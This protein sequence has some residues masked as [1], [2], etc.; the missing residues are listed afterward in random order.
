M[1]SVEM[2]S[3]GVGN[4]VCGESWIHYP[5]IFG[6]LESNLSGC[7]CLFAPIFLEVMGPM[8]GTSSFF[9]CRLRREL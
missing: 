5:D 1:K 3:V 9:E 4:S 2:E 6:Y 8:N 7:F